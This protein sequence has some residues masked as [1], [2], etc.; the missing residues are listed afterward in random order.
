MKKYIL[1]IVFY[2]FTTSF[3]QNDTVYNSYEKF[4]ITPTVNY[5]LPGM[6]IKL[7]LGYNISK[8]FS[9]ILSS[10]YMT[11]FTDPHSYIQGSVW[12][13]NSKDYIE[14]TYSDAEQTH[15]FIPITLAL[16]Y[17]LNVFGVQTYALY[18][19]GWN[20]FFNEGNYD[21]TILTKYKNSNQ[22]IESKTVKAKDIYNFSMAGSSLGG[23][24]G[25]G[26]LIPM[27]DLLKIDFS[28]LYYVINYKNST[29]RIQSLGL[30]LN[31]N[32]K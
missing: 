1:I 29:M 32:I 16:R 10:G 14:T 22:V 15:Q 26:I 30:G 12:D 11:S 5:N 24:I 7:N 9:V 28:Y 13:D 19:A 4:F 6:G 21:V 3:A 2:S 20:Y 23:G 31:Y 18:Q 17:N 8:H 27:T 25:A